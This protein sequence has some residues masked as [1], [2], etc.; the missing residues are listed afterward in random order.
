MQTISEQNHKD[1]EGNNINTIN[2]ENSTNNNNEDNV[3]NAMVSF[4]TTTYH[5]HMP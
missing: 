5:K 2:N 3:G 1:V 4:Y